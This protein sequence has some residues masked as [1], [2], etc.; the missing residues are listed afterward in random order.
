MRIMIATNAL[1]G[2]FRP[3]L[4]FAKAFHRAGHELLVVAPAS[5]GPTV[6]R[7]GLPHH[8]VP[9]VAPEVRSAAAARY[10]TLPPRQAIEALGADMMARLGPR[11]V[12]PAMLDIIRDWGPDV[13]VRETA[14]L[15]AVLAAERA[16]L[17]TVTVRIELASVIERGVHYY[18][19][20][21]EEMRAAADIPAD[22]DLERLR[23][24]T[25]ATL[26]PPSLEDPEDPGTP[27]T[28]RFR[29]PK[30]SSSQPPPWLPPGND[31][32]VYLS[33]GT[34]AG[35]DRYLGAIEAL[36]TLPI[37]LAVGLGD[38][39]D[40]AALGSMPPHVRVQRWMPQQ[41]VMPHAAAMICHGGAGSVLTGLTWGVP[42]A[43]LPI[44]GDQPDN[45]HRITTLGAGIALDGPTAIADLPAAIELLLADRS[46]R[47]VAGHIAAE[48]E[49]LSPIDTAVDLLP[50]RP[51]KPRPAISPTTRALGEATPG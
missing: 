13:V 22:P 6:R 25:Y 32:L 8:P 30:R 41:Q 3:L 23:S 1:I 38:T 46:Y 17:P 14:E 18:A 40:P 11:A 16:D 39:T 42:M 9:D 27:S 45:A 33:F 15:A 50:R 36:A 26:V 21:I 44:F 34:V 5:F 12:L 51:N 4:P 24:L 19:D 31:P 20:A 37:R 28:R 48:I 29:A 47:T 43:L 2:H 49:T 7:A 10:S 35:S